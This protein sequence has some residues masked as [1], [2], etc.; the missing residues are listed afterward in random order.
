MNKTTLYLNCIAANIISSILSQTAS[1][2][3][4][5]ASS[6]AVNSKNRN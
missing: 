2:F 1:N 6:L 5:L 4:V 3:Q